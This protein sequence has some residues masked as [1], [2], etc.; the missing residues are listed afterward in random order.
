MAVGT[1]LLLG[2]IANT[3]ATYISQQLAARGIDVL[4]HTVVGDNEQRIAELME[5]SL[6]RVDVLIITG[7]L[8]PTH[9]DL[10]R[11][12]IAR[13]TGRPL[14]RR[15]EL[16]RDLRARFERMGRPMAEMNLRQADQPKGARAIPNPRGTA[17]GVALVHEDKYIYAMP[18]VPSEMERMLDDFIL[19][20]LSTIAGDAIVLSRILAVAGVPESDLAQRLADVVSGL[21]QER[22]ATM[23]FLPSAGE[24]RIRIT[25]KDVSEEKARARIEP[26][27]AR[28]RSVL[29]SA[30]YGADEA[31][32]EASV[33]RMLEEKGLK[34]AVA[35]SIT[36]GMLASRLVDVPGASK[37]L[38]AGYITYSLEAKAD[39]GVPRDVLDSHGTVSQET[40]IAMANAARRKAGAD[41]A[42]ATCGEAGP[43]PRDEQVGSVFIA[44]AWDGG[45]VGRGFRA[46][47]E[48]AAI[49][50]WASNGALNLLRLWLMGEV[51]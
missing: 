32:L 40:A 41:V 6:A 51:G 46:P 25:A 1:E 23:A 30:V 12:A 27:E 17:P 45:S 28:I 4:Y 42:L 16:E 35:E 38:V 14:E 47:G 43:V 21:D 13:V 5:F 9:D 49:R 2:Q 33:A 18:G 19:P 29:G 48:R 50:R 7:G 31:S 24:V 20:E 8:G 26:V 11:E 22:T 3:N 34:L 10:T 39:L 44:L 15:P 37:F 36:G